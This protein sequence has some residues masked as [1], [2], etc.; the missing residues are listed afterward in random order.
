MPLASYC[1]PEAMCSYAGLCITRHK[2]AVLWNELPLSPS[3][4][5]HF[6]LL[7]FLFCFLIH[8]CLIIN[9]IYA[10]SILTTVVYCQHL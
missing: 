10:V 2:A 4:W 5:I 3:A 6:V 7:L 9:K 1:H 8:I